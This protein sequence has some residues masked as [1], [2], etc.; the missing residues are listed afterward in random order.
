MAENTSDV[1]STTTKVST[2]GNFN[3]FYH[4]D[5]NFSKLEL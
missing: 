2:P 1:K 4:I 3:Y 5:F